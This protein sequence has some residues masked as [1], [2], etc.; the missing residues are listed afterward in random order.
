MKKRRDPNSITA[1]KKKAWAELSKAIRM[2]AADDDGGYVECVTCK[3]VRHF[4]DNM[5]AGHFIDSRANA[6]LF[7]ERGIHPQCYGCNVLCNGQK[8]EYWVFM[9]QHYG[10]EVIDELRLA[11]WEIVKFT[12]DELR[13]KTAAYKARVAIQEKRLGIA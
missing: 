13:E 7:D 4:K 5:H 10:R 3:R 6:I 11:K 8:D 9:E 12:A 1:L 2:E